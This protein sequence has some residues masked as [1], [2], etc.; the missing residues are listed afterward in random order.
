[1]TLA[2]ASRDV[3]A[4]D[5][6]R[7][8]LPELRA[9]ELWGV[10]RRALVAGFD[11]ALADAAQAVLLD[12]AHNERERVDAAWGAYELALD[13]GRPPIAQRMVPDVLE[14]WSEET[15]LA[16]RGLGALY[17]QD[18][19]DSARAALAWLRDFGRRPADVP[20]SPDGRLLDALCAAEQAR[21]DL[22][23]RTTAPRTLRRLTGNEGS[24]WPPW[25]RL[26][27]AQC[28]AF[29]AVRLEPDSGP[30]RRTALERLDS[31]AT[32]GVPCWCLAVHDVT[33]RE[34][35][36]LGNPERALRAIRR[37]S[38]LSVRLLAPAKRDEGFWALAVGDTAGALR[39]WRHYL[40]LRS[41]PDPGLRPERDSVLQRFTG[42]QVQLQS[43][44]DLRN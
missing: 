23:D 34:W 30:G 42:L 6:L 29:L 9:V 32:R 21:L 28:A 25:L 10:R 41:D 7:P 19:S 15:R 2:F 27:A 24:A 3:P 5:R 14:E 16:L 17:W 36:R 1:M 22:G 38:P 44:I 20:A 31:L 43:S 18:T 37:R 11:L 33:A 4:L 26:A 8:R 13:E 40:A 12:S 39:A 35:A